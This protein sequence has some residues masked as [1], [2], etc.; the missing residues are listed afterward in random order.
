MAVGVIRL[1]V[2]RPREEQYTKSFPTVAFQ[3]LST[4]ESLVKEI[5]KGMG[6]GAKWAQICNPDLPA[7]WVAIGDLGANGKNFISGLEIPKNTYEFI[8]AVVKKERTYTVVN[9]L[10]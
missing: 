8:S 3:A 7:N 9:S 1:G 2:I 4:K 6:Y 5:F 10:C